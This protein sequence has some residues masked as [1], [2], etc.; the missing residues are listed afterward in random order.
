M[1]SRSLTVLWHVLSHLPNL[2]TLTSLDMVYPRIMTYHLPKLTGGYLVVI[3]NYFPDVL[4]ETPPKF[5]II[6]LV[7]A[8]HEISAYTCGFRVIRSKTCGFLGKCWEHHEKPLEFHIMFG[9]FYICP[10]GVVPLVKPGGP[11]KP[12]TLVT[13][14]A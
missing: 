1:D 11:L 14:V 4:F 6:A 3:W 7:V 2:I 9:L 10:V 8:L 13:L 5:P 12:P